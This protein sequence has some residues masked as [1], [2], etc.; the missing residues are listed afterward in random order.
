MHKIQSYATENRTK[1]CPCQR[2]KPTR[3]SQSSTLEHCLLAMAGATFTEHYAGK[4]NQ[5][6]TLV[7]IMSFPLTQCARVIT[8]HFQSGT[9]NRKHNE[10]SKQANMVYNGIDIITDIIYSTWYKSIKVSQEPIKYL[11]PK[12]HYCSDQSRVG[13]R[14]TI[15]APRATEQSWRLVTRLTN[16]P[17]MW[18][19][20]EYV[21]LQT[22][23]RARSWG[24]SWLKQKECLESWATSTQ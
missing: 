11:A 2:A 5:D 23:W 6:L 21:R 17:T 15:D 4:I 12:P 22:T 20:I 9:P 7:A 10:Q 14:R 18:N 3:W 16:S 8:Y 13:P 19:M 24:G 1:C